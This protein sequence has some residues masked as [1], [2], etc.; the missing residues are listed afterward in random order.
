MPFAYWQ[1]Q[2]ERAKQK[3]K[4]LQM[5]A[6]SGVVRPSHVE[7]RYSVPLIRVRTLNQAHASATPAT[8]QSF[9]RPQQAAAPSRIGAKQLL[10]WLHPTGLLLP[11]LFRR[12]GNVRAGTAEG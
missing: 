5:L 2:R 11:Q 4:A 12:L 6:L 9:V 7:L 3:R 10:E 1:T 8:M